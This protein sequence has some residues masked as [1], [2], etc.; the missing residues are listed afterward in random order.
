MATY[1]HCICPILYWWQLT[2]MSS[3]PE[4]GCPTFMHNFLCFNFSYMRTI[5]ARMFQN[6]NLLFYYFMVFLN[7][8]IIQPLWL[9]WA[10]LNY[11]FLKTWQGSQF[12]RM[13]WYILQ[14]ILWAC[15]FYLWMEI[16]INFKVDSWCPGSLEKNTTPTLNLNSK[17]FAF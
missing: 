14:R 8:R 7:V 16:K 12:V 13:M 1:W 6:K 3:K 15:I 17:K 2:Q 9:Y 5:N 4:H 11:C 10:Y